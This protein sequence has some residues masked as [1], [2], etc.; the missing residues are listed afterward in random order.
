MSLP[1]LIDLDVYG[2][3]TLRGGGDY[4]PP[5]A[6]HTRAPRLHFVGCHL[7]RGPAAYT[8]V[9]VHFAGPFFP[10]GRLICRQ[11]GTTCEGGDLRLAALATFEA[12]ANASDGALRFELIGVKSVRAFDTAV[13][14]VAVH[15]RTGDETQRLV[16]VAIA[17]GDAMAATVRATLHAVNRVAEPLLGPLG[18][19][20]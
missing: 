18:G 16:G 1:E 8:R 9:T 11:E 6:P 15:W 12:L 2:G 19:P 10:D 5:V 13:M 4:A 20:G 3:A 7:E 14:M 17:D